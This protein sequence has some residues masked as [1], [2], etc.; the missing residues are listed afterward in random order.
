MSKYT[1]EVRYICEQKSGL[2]EIKW[3]A[4]IDYI[5]SKSWNKIFTTNVNFFITD[6]LFVRRY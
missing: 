1:T 2:E 4:S 5:I 3:F 6:R